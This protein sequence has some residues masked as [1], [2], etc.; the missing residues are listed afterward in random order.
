MEELINLLNNIDDS[1]FDFVSAI[2]H[3][4]EKKESRKRKLIELITNNPNITSSEVIRFV[5]EQK[6]FYEDAAYMKAV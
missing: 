4:A 3:Y 6:D 1:Y 5:S 2:A